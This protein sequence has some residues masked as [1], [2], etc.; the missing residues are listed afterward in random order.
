MLN[1]FPVGVVLLS[2]DL[3]ASRAF[4]A[5]KLQLTVVEESD[6]AISYTSGAT[7]LT[8]TAST[9]GSNDEQT[10]ASWRVDDVREVLDWLAT[11]GVEPEEYDTEDLKTVDGVADRGSVWSAY[12]IDPDGNALGIEQPK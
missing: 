8:V 1:T 2:T 6:D 11:R 7:R 9:E 3:K 5:D 12:I 10:K 4:Y